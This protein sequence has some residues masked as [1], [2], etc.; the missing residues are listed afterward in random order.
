MATESMSQTSIE[1]IHGQGFTEVVFRRRGLLWRLLRVVLFAAA[2]L[3]GLMLGVVLMAAGGNGP[4][5]FFPVWLAAWGLGGLVFL[6]GFLWNALGVESL[7]AR[8]ESLTLMR[9]MLF[10]RSPLV[11]PANSI[12]DI[13]WMAD[14]PSRA[15]RVNGRRIPQTGIEIV[16]DDRTLRCAT[17]LGQAEAATAIAELRQRLVI[18]KRRPQ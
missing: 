6:V 18:P 10:L 9:R 4:S 5:W 15:V 13:R 3:F 8:S 14:D 12:G 7:V 2:W 17:G 16:A 1:T 11:V